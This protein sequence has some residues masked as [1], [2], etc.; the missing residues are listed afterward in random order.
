MIREEVA[1]VAQIQTIFDSRE[2]IPVYIWMR[3]RLHVER[4]ATL[5]STISTAST[6]SS[7][8]VVCHRQQKIFRHHQ[9]LL[10]VQFLCRLHSGPTSSELSRKRK[11][12]PRVKLTMHGPTST[13]RKLEERLQVSK[14]GRSSQRVR[15]YTGE[16]LLQS[17]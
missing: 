13:S 8:I 1:I 12:K 9:V 16:N 7:T 11:V 14:I 2:V 10:V 6:S 15:Q 3:R 5:K 4:P 17:V